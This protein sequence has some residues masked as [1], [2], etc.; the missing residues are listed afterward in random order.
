M[1]EQ[2]RGRH[3]LIL[4][5]PDQAFDFLEPKYAGVKNVRVL[6]IPGLRFHYTD[7]RL[8]L[9]KSV[10]LGFSFLSR[11]AGVVKHVSRLLKRENADLAIT[12]FEPA[13]SRAAHRCD[14]PFISLD[15]QHFIV[16][17]DLSILP[18]SL[19][20]YAWGMGWVVRAH[21]TRQAK[22]IV[23]AFYFPPLKPGFEDVV[24][25][26]PLLRPEILHAQPTTGDYLLSYLRRHT[27]AR[28]VEMMAQLDRPIR[29][30]GLGERPPLGKLT[31]HAISE[32]NFTRDL[33][34]ANALIAAAGNQLIGESLYLG[35]PMFVMPEDTHH[36]QMINAHFL[37]HMGCGAWTEVQKVS[38]RHLQAFLGQLDHYREGIRPWQPRLD[39]TTAA[40]QQ[41]E[42]VL[43]ENDTARHQSPKLL[44]A[45]A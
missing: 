7:G 41:I 10:A 17:Y 27:P 9:F 33:I 30:Y 2:L 28:V 14:I 25:I 23:S 44:A 38:V 20:Q 37:G 43:Q 42:A 32:E 12:D 21:H 45:S 5:A 6:R 4:L 29:V 13:L 1:V 22:T 8:D 3:D 26:G 19:R 39:G 34:G 31:F 40:L 36:E 24:Q 11:L 15:H 18:L 35:K 16:A